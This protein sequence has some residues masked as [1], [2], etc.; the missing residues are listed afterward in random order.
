MKSS[1]NIKQKS[2]RERINSSKDN[3]AENNQIKVPHPPGPP[4][5]TRRPTIISARKVRLSN[6]S[7]NEKVNGKLCARIESSFRTIKTIELFSR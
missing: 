7:L 5:S 3:K 4:Q 6:K 2:I 1:A